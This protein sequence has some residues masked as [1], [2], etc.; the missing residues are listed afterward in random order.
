MASKTPP[1]VLYLEDVLGQLSHHCENMEV[2]WEGHVRPPK[3]CICKACVLAGGLDAMLT[4]EW[5]ERCGKA[6]GTLPPSVVDAGAGEPKDSP[7]P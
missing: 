2:T 4:A 1:V 6:N 7:E 3:D 5:E